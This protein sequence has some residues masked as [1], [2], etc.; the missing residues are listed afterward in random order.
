MMKNETIVCA[1]VIVV[2]ILVIIRLATNQGKMMENYE[3]VD[4]DNSE[5]WKRKEKSPYVLFAERAY[6]M[7]VDKDWLGR[8]RY[9]IP[10]KDYFIY[11]CNRLG[12]NAPYRDGGCEDSMDFQ[13]KEGACTTL[14]CNK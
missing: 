2:L 13:R 14:W 5:T 10:E 9:R 6:N 11:Q 12:E 8:K 4:W 1:V 3:L 7:D